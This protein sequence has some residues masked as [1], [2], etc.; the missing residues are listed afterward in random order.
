MNQ[1]RLIGGA[2]RNW[3]SIAGV[4]PTS[5]VRSTDASIRGVILCRRVVISDLTPEE[6]A[7]ALPHLTDR[8]ELDRDRH[9]DHRGIGELR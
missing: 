7:V 2:S 1:A 3:I 4:A 6:A 5:A 8:V 9:F